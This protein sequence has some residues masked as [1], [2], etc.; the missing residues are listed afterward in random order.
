MSG[1]LATDTKAS[2]RGFTLIELLVVI[3]IIALLSSVVLS[4]LNT[5]R[6]KSR[7]AM[8]ISE[9]REIQKALETYY[10]QNNAYPTTGGGW[11][12][13]SPDCYG[14][15]P[16]LGSASSIPNLSPTY[17]STIP[18]EVQPSTGRCFLY[19]SDGVDYK[20]LAHQTMESCVSGTCL[21]QDPARM[22]Q[23]TSSVYTDGAR[24][25]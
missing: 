3:A 21:L 14:A 10:L 18:Q 17:I 16:S 5:A 7:D 4:A 12:G 22:S 8:R 2:H 20:F 24:S 15:Y 1:D 11:R 25:W 19:R 9:L 13:N 23:Q 6:A